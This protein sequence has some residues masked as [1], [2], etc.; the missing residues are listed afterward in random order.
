MDYLTLRARRATNLGGHGALTS[1]LDLGSGSA[2]VPLR[3]AALADMH[4][5][6][7]KGESPG[8]IAEPSLQTPR[9]D[10]NDCGS[11][12]SRFF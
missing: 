3:K 9:M 2:L 7:N 8:S 10:I 12:G 6:H 5:A 4:H 11:Q 1:G